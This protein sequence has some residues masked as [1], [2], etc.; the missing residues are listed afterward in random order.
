MA[1][2]CSFYIIFQVLKVPTSYKK[3]YK[4]EPPDLATLLLSFS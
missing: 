2:A 1:N 3:N 4:I